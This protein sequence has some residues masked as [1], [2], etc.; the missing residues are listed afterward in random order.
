MKKHEITFSVIKIPLDF[1]TI[2]TSFFIAKTLREITDLIPGV[3]LPVQTISNE[4]LLVF[5][6][7]WWILWVIVFAIHGLYSIKISH[8]KIKELLD[9]LWYSIY[10]FMFFSLFVYLSNGILYSEEIPRLIIL[11]STIIASIGIICQR[12]LLNYIQS[13]L[14]SREVIKK[15]NILLVTNKKTEKNKKI[16]QDIQKAKIYHI[17]GYINTHEVDEKNLKYRGS[18]DWFLK[19]LEQREIDEILV[20][21]SDFSKEELYEIWDESRIYGV[22][23][24]YVTNYFDMSAPSTTLSLISSIPTIEIKNTNLENWGRVW[25]RIFDILFSLFF[26]VLLFPFLV[27]IAILIKIEDPSAPVI[28]KNKRVGFKGR[29]FFLYKFRYLK[30]EFCTNEWDTHALKIEEELIQKQSQRDWPLYK[31]QNDPRKTKIGTF[32]ERYSIDELPQLYNVI[33]GNMSLVWPRPHQPREV[34]KYKLYQKRVLTVKPWIT[35]MWQINGRDKNTFDKEVKL[36]IFYIENW[37]FVLDLKIIIKTF[38]ILF[39]RK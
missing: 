11:F 3:H 20:I 30:K 4:S 31:I 35:G 2:L 29:H 14:I 28:F 7:F 33:L 27:F 22:R 9:V 10:F 38:P 8:S 32:I 6:L 39:Q 26:L 1:L 25:K 34:E 18:V 21:D 37:S 24:R 23:Y 5:A 15:R 19:L 13:I 17:I 12:L 16:I 36:D